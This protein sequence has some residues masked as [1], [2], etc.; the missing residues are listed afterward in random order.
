MLEVSLQNR[1]SEI[2]AV[3]E[4]LD[5][6]AVRHG[7]PAR[8]VARLHL[9]L[10]EH[11]TNIISHGYKPGAVGAITV[12]FALEPSLIRVEIEDDAG[13]FNLLEAPAANT[14]LPMEEKPLGGLGV[15]LIRQSVD[16][17]E[18]RRA[19]NRNVLVMKNRLPAS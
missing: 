17:L 6:M 3:H 9:A 10:E 15:H 7:L 5:Q 13:P 1:S 18:Y 8:L 19:A 12:R 4:A 16:Q 14:A 11:L 2:P